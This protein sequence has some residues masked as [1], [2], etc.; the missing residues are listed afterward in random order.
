VQPQGKSDSR[1][2]GLKRDG[3]RVTFCQLK[4][5]QDQGFDMNKERLTADLIRMVFQAAEETVD[6]TLTP[7]EEAEVERI[8]RQKRKFSV[9]LTG[10]TPVRLEAAVPYSQYTYLNVGITPQFRGILKLQTEAA[11]L[12]EQTMCNSISK[13]WSFPWTKGTLEMV[14]EPIDPSTGGLIEIAFSFSGK[15]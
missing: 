1:I 6:D 8:Q 13:E 3:R 4:Y 11:E 10:P 9:N 5:A 14:I 12:N 2:G 15:P 7:E